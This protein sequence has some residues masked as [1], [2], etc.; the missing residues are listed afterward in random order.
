MR[1]AG[2]EL[3]ARVVEKNIL[4]GQVRLHHFKSSIKCCRML[5]C[6]AHINICQL[7]SKGVKADTKR[8]N[9]AFQRRLV[10][11][12]LI[13]DPAAPCKVFRLVMIKPDQIAPRSIYL[14]NSVLELPTLG[15]I[16]ITDQAPFLRMLS[17]VS[18][19]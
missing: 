10:R 6:D 15:E 5:V 13:Q 2:V 19:Q 1:S 12:V 14:L 11:L 18:S 17:M 16:N 9:G 4:I 8:Q 3:L 7:H